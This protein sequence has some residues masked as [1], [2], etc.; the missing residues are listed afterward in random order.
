M[1]KIVLKILQGHTNRVRW[2]NYNLPVAISY[3]WYDGCWLLASYYTVI[4]SLSAIHDY[5]QRAIASAAQHL[6]QCIQ[7]HYSTIQ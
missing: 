3:T 5:L 2:A 1:G 6:L 4:N 7:V